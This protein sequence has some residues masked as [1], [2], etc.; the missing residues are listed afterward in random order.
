VKIRKCGK[1][2]NGSDFHRVCVK[3]PNK[4]TLYGQAQ[5]IPIT[6][7]VRY[8]TKLNGKKSKF[9]VNSNN[10]TYSNPIIDYQLSVRRKFFK[11]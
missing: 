3:S 11:N 9:S 2:E 5:T 4:Y 1:I 8:Y 7:V 6:G 10:I